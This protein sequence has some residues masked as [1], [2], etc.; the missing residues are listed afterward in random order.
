MTRGLRVR[1]PLLLVVALGFWLWR[2]DFFPQPRELVLLLPAP[3]ARVDVQLYS[4]GG[5]LL[6]R[7]ERADAPPVVRMEI[8]LRRGRY[9][10]RAF[11]RGE[12]GA[13]RSLSREFEIGSERVNEVELK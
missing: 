9:L 10:A 7:E 11:L 8:S 5:E 2:S 4:E 6:A 1:L 3:A 13:E 12:S